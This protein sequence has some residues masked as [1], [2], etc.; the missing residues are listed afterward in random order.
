MVG[1]A[2]LFW[3]FFFGDQCGFCEN[4]A[5]QA[6]GARRWRPGD[7]ARAHL[8]PWQLLGAPRMMCWRG[9][10]QHAPVCA[11]CF[12]FVVLSGAVLMC[13][14]LFSLPL[15]LRR[16]W[17]LGGRKPPPNPACGAAVGHTGAPKLIHGT[18]IWQS[19][20]TCCSTNI[21][22]TKPQPCT[23]IFTIILPIKIAQPS[24][25]HH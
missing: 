11:P 9:R 1:T 25:W 4:A 23:L 21:H 17:Q 12:L 7:L 13:M 3:P 6:T 2:R 20:G 15:L 22:G 10:V 19:L 18:P 16:T 5:G 24:R 8:A 14:L